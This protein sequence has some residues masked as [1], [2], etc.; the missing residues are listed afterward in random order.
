MTITITAF[1][2]SPDQGRG[3]ARDM[4]VRWALEEL[5]IPYEVKLLSFDELKEPRHLARHPFGQIPTYE[6][7][8]TV[9]F[10]S[11]AIVIHLADRFPGLLPQD[12]SAR[13]RAIC[14]IFAALNTVEPPVLELETTGFFDKTES[15]YEDRL[16][17]VED[18][19][20]VRLDQLSQRLG[21][22]P[23]LEDEFNAGDLVMA[24]VLFRLKSTNLLAEFDN[25]TSYL[26]R[27]EARPAYNRAFAAQLAVFKDRTKIQGE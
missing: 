26:S 20:R 2:N 17:L 7:N 9:L 4:R 13:A 10:E 18:R 19:V 3:L 16:P 24:G 22:A 12:D 23:W 15:W 8:D 27:A 25:L 6:D 1:A 11:G 14:W 5:N 21:K